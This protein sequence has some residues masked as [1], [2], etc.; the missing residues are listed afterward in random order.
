V[1]EGDMPKSRSDGKMGQPPRVKS[2][3]LDKDEQTALEEEMTASGRNDAVPREGLVGAHAERREPAGRAATAGEDDSEELEVTA[4]IDVFNEPT[5][6]GSDVG[7]TKRAAERERERHRLEREL[8]R[9]P[10]GEEGLIRGRRAENVSRE[11][12]DQAAGKADEHVAGRDL[13]KKA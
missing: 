3:P 13:R 12:L 6:D 5:R 9:T 10:A 7:P 1:K 8:G 2:V 11:D 4:E